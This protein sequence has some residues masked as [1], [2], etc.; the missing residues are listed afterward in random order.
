MQDRNGMWDIQLKTNKEVKKKSVDVCDKEAFLVSCLQ[1][2]L[3]GS[4]SQSI[5]HVYLKSA[6]SV[7]IKKHNHFTVGPNF[8]LIHRL[9]KQ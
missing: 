6:N 5:K 8:F 4:V 9:V 3:L 2:F 1:M 7:T